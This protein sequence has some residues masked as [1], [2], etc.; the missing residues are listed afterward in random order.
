MWDLCTPQGLSLSITSEELCSGLEKTCR[1]SLDQQYKHITIRG[2]YFPK[3]VLNQ[4]FRHDIN[5]YYANFLFKT[6]FSFENLNFSS[7]FVGETIFWMLKKFQ[8][9]I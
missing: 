4:K 7:V 2:R 9:Q 5:V 6:E 3:V 8:Q 1:Q